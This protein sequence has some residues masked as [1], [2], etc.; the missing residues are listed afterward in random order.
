MSKKITAKEVRKK[1]RRISN[2][3]GYEYTYEYPTYEDEHGQVLESLDCH[4][5]DSAGNPSCIVG[6]LLYDVAPALYRKL[7]QY[8]WDSTGYG[9]PRSVAVNSLVEGSPMYEG[10]T[11]VN[12]S[13]IFEPEAIQ[14]L[15]S[16]QRYQDD[17]DSWGEAVD[18]VA[19]RY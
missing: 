4:Y 11:G 10:D 14:V 3:R 12:L 5:S 13:D 16:V 18:A 15:C 19:E 1:L 2:E 6:A 17:G 9:E 7:H 8:E